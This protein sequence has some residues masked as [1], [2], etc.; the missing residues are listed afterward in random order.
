MSLN[1]IREYK[2]LAKISKFTVSKNML[3]GFEEAVLGPS[4]N[5]WMD[6]DMFAM[7]L[8]TVFKPGL[9]VRQVKGPVLPFVDDHTTHISQEASDFC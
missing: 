3:E 5:G 7:W 1:A 9:N 4:D 8:K 2:I 6:I